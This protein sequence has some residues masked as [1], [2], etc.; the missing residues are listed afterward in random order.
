[1]SMTLKRNLSSSSITVGISTFEV[2][3]MPSPTNFRSEKKLPLTGSER[4]FIAQAP[5]IL[6]AS[7]SVADESIT[8]S[9]LVRRKAPIDTGSFQQGKHLTH[10]A[11]D[12]QHGA[13]PAAV[14]AVHAFAIEYG[15]HA[16]TAPDAGRRTIQIT[17]SQ[18]ALE[19]AFSVT[20]QSHTA[21]DGGQLR[22]REGAIYLP[23][24]LIGKVDAVL[25]LDNRP[26]AKPHFRVAKPH[27]SNVSYTP[28]QVAEAYGFPANAKATGQTIGL[29]ELGGG[30]RPADITAYFA[31]LKL[32]PPAVTAV[33][34]D[35]GKNT[36]G[37][38][39]GADGEVML[40]IEVAGSVATGAAIAVYFAGNTDQGFLDAITTAVHDTT[41]KPGVISISWGGPESSW[42]AQAMTAMDE[43][44]QAAAAMGITITV[45]AG[46]DGATDGVSGTAKHVDFPASSPHVLACG[47]TKLTASGATI[48]SEVV[49]NELAAGEGATGGGVSAVFAKPTWQSAANVPAPTVNSGGR[50]V[51]DVAGDADPS[52]GYVVRV[53]GQT[54][55]IGGTSAVAPLWAG[56]IALANAANKNSAG[57][58][59]P[60]L[61]SKGASAFRDITQGNNGGFTAA[62]GWDACT[63]L[64]S[65]VGTAIVKLLG[66]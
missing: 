33:S 60:T 56:L 51:P 36:P 15:L 12:R 45:A 26:Q 57:F 18:A 35:G 1:M 25:G 52:T 3:A 31:S 49:W 4:K 21:A 7:P 54:S 59:N 2:Q 8:V 37:T 6:S 11:F 17:G 20:L 23:E 43:A 41:H 29:I 16:I 14:E 39:N 22:V 24:S 34:V 10:E 42:T 28:V 48:Q 66:S 13:D 27:A 46:D 58:I 32:T 5:H 55:V 65:P 62:V 61:Y 9:V 47:G 50:G 44:C 19:E 64:G 40:D 63:G 53:D 30:F 38:A